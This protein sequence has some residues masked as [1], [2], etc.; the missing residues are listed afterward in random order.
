MNSLP[1][2]HRRIEI[3]KI[4]WRNGMTAFWL[5]VIAIVTMLTDHVGAVFFPGFAISFLGSEWE[6][7][8]IIGRIAFPIFAYQIAEGAG[9]TSNWKKYAL[10]LLL[11]GVISEIPFDL[12]LY[13]SI[14]LQK[15]NV[16]VTL[17]LGLLAIRLDMYFVKKDIWFGRMKGLLFTGVCM[18][19]AWGIRCDYSFFGVIMIYW[20]YLTRT[21]PIMM[22]LGN[23]I[24]ECT[25]GG[26][27]PFGLFALIPIG[28]YN[29][30]K[31]Y[32]KKWIKWLGYAFYPAHLIVIAGIR[33][34]I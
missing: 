18:A 8:R 26:L 28:F 13:G 30:E 31:G 4:E 5:R 15:Q 34:V 12:A 25:M 21:E 32:E 11:F 17:L 10:R 20:F 16:Y 14:T 19:I 22:G 9:H 6:I 1:G 24:I 33:A 29:H 7:F 23:A 3:L 2:C 27:Q